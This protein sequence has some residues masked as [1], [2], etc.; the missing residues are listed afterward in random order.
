VTPSPSATIATPTPTVSPTP[1]SS[2][3]AGGTVGYSV[4]FYYLPNCPHCAALESSSSFQQLQNEVP[5]SWIVW[6]GSNG[7]GVTEAPTLILLKNG[8]EVTRCV[9]CEDAT[10]ILAYIHGG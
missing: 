1:S 6:N 5:V 9:G 10:S 2:P 8:I 4:L 7:S 3:S